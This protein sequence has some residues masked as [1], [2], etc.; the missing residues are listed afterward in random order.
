MDSGPL[1]VG[2]VEGSSHQSVTSPVQ[3]ALTINLFLVE[4][5]PGA[6]LSRSHWAQPSQ[7]TAHNT[8]HSQ[9]RYD[10]IIITNIT[11]I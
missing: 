2:V 11:I 1:A 9:S 10:D 7:Y 3:T 5:N 6:Q 4:I 8:Q